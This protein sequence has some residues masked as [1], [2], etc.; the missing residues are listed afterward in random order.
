MVGM[1]TM[2]GSKAGLF[3]LVAAFACLPGCAVVTTTAS[4][5]GAVV[6]TTADV[7]TTAV[8]T[9]ADIVTSPVRSGDGGGH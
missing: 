8:K 4:V 3:F 2:L 6:E 1:G 5:V 7:A 9:T